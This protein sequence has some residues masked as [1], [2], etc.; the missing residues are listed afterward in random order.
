MEGSFH[1]LAQLGPVFLLKIPI[2]SQNSAR[3]LD[4]PCAIFVLKD[5]PT[6]YLGMMVQPGTFLASVVEPYVRLFDLLYGGS[7]NVTA[8]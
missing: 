1:Q 3:D 6:S 2:T 8:V 5:G 7:Y 4:Q